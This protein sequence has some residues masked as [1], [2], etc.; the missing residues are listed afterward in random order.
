MRDEDIH[1]SVLF[2]RK[3][4]DNFASG[5]QSSRLIGLPAGAGLSQEICPELGC[6]RGPTY[7]G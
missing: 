7:K 3:M 2:G 1:C 5:H 4:K 6:F